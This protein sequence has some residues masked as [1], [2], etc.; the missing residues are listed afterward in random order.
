MYCGW[1][2]EP[3]ACHWVPPFGFVSGGLSLVFSFLHFL[4]FLKNSKGTPG[5]ECNICCGLQGWWNKVARGKCYVWFWNTVLS[6]STCVPWPGSEFNLHQ[7]WGGETVA[8]LRVQLLRACQPKSVSEVQSDCWC[9]CQLGRLRTL[10]LPCKQD[11]EA[12]PCPLHTFPRESLSWNNLA[13]CSFWLKREIFIMSAL[14]ASGSEMS[15][16]P[17]AAGSS[18]GSVCFPS[19]GHAVTLFSSSWDPDASL[20]VLPTQ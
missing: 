13:Q 8:A 5:R 14:R 11:T 6:L 3:W 17:S 4:S 2:R 1:N 12:F 9:L 10:G 16:C 18:S 15:T 19:P 7:G 20:E